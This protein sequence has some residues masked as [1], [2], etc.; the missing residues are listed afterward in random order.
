MRKLPERFPRDFA[1]ARYAQGLVT[2]FLGF[3][4]ALWFGLRVADGLGKHLAQLSLRLRR[5][6]R[7]FLPLGHPVHMGMPHGELNPYR[8]K[9]C[10]CADFWRSSAAWCRELYLIPRLGFG[11]LVSKPFGAWS[12]EGHPASRASYAVENARLGRAAGAVSVLVSTCR[13]DQHCRAAETCRHRCC[14]RWSLDHRPV[15]H[16]RGLCRQPASR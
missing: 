13:S 6:A 2:I 9:V 12:N 4:P 10:G 15:R 16:C 8:P 1:G 14:R 5:L 11:D 7:C 3:R